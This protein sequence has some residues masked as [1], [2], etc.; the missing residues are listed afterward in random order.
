MEKI[1]L[2]SLGCAKNRVDAEMMLY[3]LKENGYEIVAD[4]ADGDAVIVNTCGFIESAK[5]ESIDEILELAKLKK[6]GRI[7]AI[8]VTGC[9][10][11]RYQ[12]EIFKELYEVDAVIGIGANN[13]IVSVVQKALNGEKTE[14]FPQKTLMPLDGGRLQTTPQAFAY[15]KVADG[16]DNCC[17]YCAIP[18]IRGRFRSRKMESI[19]E[20]AKN[21]AENGVKEL[22]VIAQDTT[23]YGEDIYGKLMLPELLR[24]LCKIEKIHWI[25]LLYCYPDRITDELIGLI[26]SEEKILNYIDIPL[27]HC[28]KDI[29]HAM[30]RQGG[31][32]ILTA[33]LNKIRTKIPGVVLRTTFIAGFPGETEENFVELSEF[34]NDIRFERTGC[35]TY[36]QE[37]DTKAAV[38]ENQ[39]PEDEKSR[40]Q[41]ILVN[42]AQTIMD[43]FNRSLLGKTLTVLTEGYDRLAKVYFGRS[44]ADAPE[45]D[46]KVFFTTDNKKPIPGDFVEVKINDVIDG[47][48]IGEMI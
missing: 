10:A 30:N 27:Q 7:K 20:E 46:G 1:G 17:S 25:R 40:R 19:I 44:Y 9:L 16:C 47:D 2:V 24:E 39:I 42:Q 8:I 18:L 4:E 38:M 15:L 43:E 11:E 35:F 3:K 34:V 21:L 22:L 29:L 32:E 37:E 14:C 33:L 6:E 36:S 5:T 26:A 31:R 45:V 41:E 13:D 28:N 12:K 48:P 23:R